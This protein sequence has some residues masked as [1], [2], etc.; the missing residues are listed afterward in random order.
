M[1]GVGLGRILDLMSF[2][3]LGA[4]L[5]VSLTVGP[6]E[7]LALPAASGSLH[8]LPFSWHPSRS[9]G[10][11]GTRV[12]GSQAASSAPGILAA[13]GKRVGGFRAQNSNRSH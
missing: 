7:W 8:L 2:E 1:L 10:D 13:L 9:Y 6:G 3:P 5:S 4:S 12:E 11:L